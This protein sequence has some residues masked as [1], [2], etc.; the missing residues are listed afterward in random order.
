M[1]QIASLVLKNA[2]D[3]NV[4]YTPQ[5][6]DPG[7][8][9]VWK[10]RAADVPALQG[11]AQVTFRESA[12]VRHVSGK[13]TLPYARVDGSVIDHEVGSFKLSTPMHFTGAQRAELVKQLASL[14]ANAVVVSA[15]NDGEMPF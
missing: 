6:V 11:V 12:T 10:N 8:I 3:A 7:S 15:N 9:A 14:I 4:T 13:V 1:A 2:A 5:A